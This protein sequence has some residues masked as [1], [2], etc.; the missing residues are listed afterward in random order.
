MLIL[1]SCGERIPPSCDEVT[2]EMVEK[3]AD[4]IRDNSNNDYKWVAKA[5]YK[6]ETIFF[7]PDYAAN[8]FFVVWD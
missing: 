8:I 2:G 5:Q 6:G 1:S 4:R 7:T 3:W